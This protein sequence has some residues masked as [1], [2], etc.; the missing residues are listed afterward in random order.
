MRWNERWRSWMK[1]TSID[2]CRSFSC[3][4]FRL[5]AFEKFLPIFRKKEE[6]ETESHIQVLTRTELF[7]DH[8]KYPFDRAEIMKIF[9]VLLSTNIHEIKNSPNFIDF[10]Q[11][12][13]CIAC[14]RAQESKCFTQEMPVYDTW[15][16]RIV[17]WQFNRWALQWA[18]FYCIYFS[19]NSAD[20]VNNAV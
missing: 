15:C 7:I 12:P 5:S 16:S 8:S 19:D 6:K 2:I 11:Q 9:I 20:I 1:C 10:N 4:M 18:A 3:H 17:C 13:N 14:I